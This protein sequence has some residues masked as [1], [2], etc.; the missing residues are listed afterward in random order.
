MSVIVSNYS[1]PLYQ[2]SYRGCHM[3]FVSVADFYL[4]VQS[5][6][7]ADHFFRLVEHEFNLTSLSTFHVTQSFMLPYLDAALI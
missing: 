3:L 4:A 5:A 7:N 2:L 6:S 1:P